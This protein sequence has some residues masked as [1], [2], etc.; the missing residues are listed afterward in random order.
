MLTRTEI[1]ELRPV[2][3][4]S[5]SIKSEELFEKRAYWKVLA[6]FIARAPDFP[7]MD[8]AHNKG[9]VDESPS[10]SRG[11]RVFSISFGSTLGVAIACL[12]NTRCDIETAASLWSFLGDECQKRGTMGG[13]WCFVCKSFE[14]VFRHVGILLRSV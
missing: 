7:I 9:Q 14:M 10:K 8:L 6:E 11:S 5:D 1:N 13:R 2:T 3:D 12:F 4:T